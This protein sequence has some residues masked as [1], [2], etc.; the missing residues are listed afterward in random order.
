MDCWG[1]YSS[2]LEVS[3]GVNVLFSAWDGVYDKLHHRMQAKYDE[4]AAELESRTNTL[5]I[6]QK[7]IEDLKRRNRKNYNKTR[8]NGRIC[9]ISIATAIACSLFF[10]SS[11]KTVSLGVSILIGLSI[12]A[13][14][15]I[16]CVMVYWYKRDAKRARED[17]YQFLWIMRKAS[18][19]A[20]QQISREGN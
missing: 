9:S 6:P 4:E 2:F 1:H 5:D 10:V 8:R 19:L 15:I 16:A 13:A 18:E 20:A 14:P 12:L 7:E 11:D 3:F 17:H